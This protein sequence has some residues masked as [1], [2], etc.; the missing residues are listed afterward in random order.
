MTLP[1]GRMT[2]A[3]QGR[4]DLVSGVRSGIRF[5]RVPSSL[6]ALIRQLPGLE[7]GVIETGVRE[8]VTETISGGQIVLLIISIIKVDSYWIWISVYPQLCSDA[9][10]TFIVVHLR[11]RIQVSVDEFDLNGPF[12]EAFGDGVWQASAG[13][14]ISVQDV[15]DAV[16]SLLAYREPN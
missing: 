16:A 3:R 11:L 1:S 9:I 7:V 8:T 13:V 14:V 10:H 6:V 2:Y 15:D 5:A 12:F 4:S